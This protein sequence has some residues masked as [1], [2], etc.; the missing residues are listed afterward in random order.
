[1]KRMLIV[2]DDDN[3]NRGISF[4]FERDGFVISGVSTIQEGWAIFKQYQFDIVIL[5]LGLPDG[6]GME[7]CRKIRECSNVAIIMLTACD[8]ETDEVAGLMAGA[9]D[10]VTKPF[11]LSVL[12]VRVERLLSRT[13]L[14]ESAMIYSYDYKLDLNLCKFYKE[15][16]EILLTKVEFRLISCLMNNVGRVLSKEQI[17]AK[18]WDNHGNFIDENTLSVNISRLRAKVEKNPKKPEIL[19]T[20]R[21]IGYVWN[22]E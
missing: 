6:N 16:E 12:R 9:D 18:L 2:E 3:L 7:L 13:S 1:M 17:L 4:A 19:K 11:S 10:Y 14:K 15:G 21:G 22:K 8:L 20:V 5:D